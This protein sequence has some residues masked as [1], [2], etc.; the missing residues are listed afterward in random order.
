MLFFLRFYNWCFDFEIEVIL[1]QIN[2]FIFHSFF[3]V[4]F[5]LLFDSESRGLVFFTNPP[6]TDQKIGER[7]NLPTNLFL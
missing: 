1:V 6:K 5:L 2:F 7:L 3:F 4:C